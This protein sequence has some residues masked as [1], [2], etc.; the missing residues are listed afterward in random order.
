[1][2]ELFK[3]QEFFEITISVNDH[4]IIRSIFEKK[5]QDIDHNLQIFMDRME[6]LDDLFK[7]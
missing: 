5:L 3:Q 2:F 1:M 7:K 6:E 4:R